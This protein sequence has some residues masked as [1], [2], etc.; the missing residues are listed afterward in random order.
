MIDDEASEPYQYY[1]PSM[2]ILLIHLSDISQVPIL[3]II[4]GKIW[5]LALNIKKYNTAL[6]FNKNYLFASRYM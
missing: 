5:T 6:T 4:I 3:H 1:T 2:H